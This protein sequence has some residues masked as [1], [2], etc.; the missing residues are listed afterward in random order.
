[1]TDHS[2]IPTWRW[3]GAALAAILGTVAGIFGVRR[4]R[5]KPDSSNM[6]PPSLPLPVTGWL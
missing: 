6:W 4:M 3:I 2:K 1:M 5:G